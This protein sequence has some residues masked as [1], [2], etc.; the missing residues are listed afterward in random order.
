MSTYTIT[1]ARAHL[2]EVIETAKTEAVVLERNGHPAAVVVS[3]ERYSELM[4]ALEE[5]E[6]AAAVDAALAAGGEP[7]PWDQVMKDLGWTE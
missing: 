1:H 2:P 5:V 7:I 6:D 4:D 3:P